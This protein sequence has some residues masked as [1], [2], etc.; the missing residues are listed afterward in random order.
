MKQG[1]PAQGPGKSKGSILVLLI[2]LGLLFVLFLGLMVASWPQAF[3]SSTAD[4]SGQLP[5]RKPGNTAF[6][7][8]RLSEDRAL[9][10]AQPGGIMLVPTGGGAP[11]MLDTPGYRY[12]HAV[13]PLLT[14]AGQVLYSGSGI[15]LVDPFAGQPRQIAA[16]PADRVI[17][18][19]VLSP[20][21]AFLAWS[22]VPRDGNGRVEIY[23]GPLAQT[24]RVYQQE[25]GDCPC[26]RAFAWFA[27]PGADSGT[28]GALLLTNDYGDSSI[29]RDGLWLLDLKSGQTGAPRQVLPDNPPQGPLA[30][31]PQTAQLLYTHTWGYVPMAEDGSVPG[32][33]ATESYANDLALAR[34]DSA[35]TQLQSAQTIVSGQQLREMQ[36]TSEPVHYQS[37]PVTTEY[38]WIATPRFSPDGSQLAY[39][40]FTS[41][42]A[43]P[44]K[45]QSSLYLVQ[46]QGG[47]AHV[48]L[49]PAQLQ[50]IAP[51]GYFELGSWLD[52]H[53]VTLIEKNTLYA[54]NL[55]QG[56]LAKIADVG[57]YGSIVATVAQP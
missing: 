22:S 36:V 42:L 18:S 2:V 23:A 5:L 50:A 33:L 21:G 28:G 37:T 32:E 20:D 30:F 16:L 29:V 17:T 48:S 13:P 47:G 39:V 11:R 46:M 3:S 14:P 6:S 34:L 43:A 49:S 41:D 53:T 45:R 31:V 27:S 8:L 15:W 7:A 44:F 57:A 55:Q 35:S 54:L 9:I 12:D 40:Q 24:A 52:A 56:A 38:H 51:D 1:A 19:L 10:Y 4:R 26:F 25:T